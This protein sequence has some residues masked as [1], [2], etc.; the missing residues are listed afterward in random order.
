[1]VEEKFQGVK[2]NKKIICES[3]KLNILLFT[4]ALSEILPQVIIIITPNRRKL[5]VSLKQRYLKNYFSQTES[6]KD[7]GAEKMPKLKL[8][9][10]LFTNFNEIPPL[11]Q[12]LRFWFV[13][14]SHNLDSSLLKWKG[15]LT[16]LG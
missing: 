5:S 1:M 8:T 15:S 3:K 13:L 2:I 10:V 6:G 9:K 12:H 4:H 14:L 16:R 11:L 7:Y